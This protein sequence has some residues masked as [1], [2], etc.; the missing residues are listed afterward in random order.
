MILIAHRGNFEGRN[1]KSENEPEYVNKALEKGFEVEIDVW[2]KN[3]E[4]WLG[5]DKPE[6]KTDLEFL[7]KK[8]LWCHAKNLLALEEL[9]KNKIHCFWHEEDERVV[10]SK[11]YIWTYP[12]KTLGKKSI[13]VMPE[14]V[15][16]WD[17]SD[18]L[19]VCSDNLTSYV[20]K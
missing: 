8:G 1:I 14:W 12:G 16:D 2:F 6:Y 9:L 3:N 20:D 19:G 11:G 15:D 10:T 17:V 7:K 18:A 4:W 13:A 5:H